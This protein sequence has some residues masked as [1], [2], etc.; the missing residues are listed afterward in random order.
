M[1]KNSWTITGKHDVKTKTFSKN[2]ENQCHSAE[3]TWLLIMMLRTIPS[4]AGAAGE[5]SSSPSLADIGAGGL[6][7]ELEPA[8]EVMSGISGSK[9][10]HFLFIQIKMDF[11]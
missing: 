9:E 10:T 11:L 8:S 3:C 1:N 7:L 2:G 4:A 5:L 6:S